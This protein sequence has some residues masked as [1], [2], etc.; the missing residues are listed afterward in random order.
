M[1]L[2]QTLEELRGY[3]KLERVL[4]LFCVA[5]PLLM[6]WVDDGP[7]RDS[8]SAYY[9]MTQNQWFYFPLTAAAMLFLVNG[10]VKG[11]AWYNAWLGVFLTGVVLLNHQDFKLPHGAFAIAFFVGN[12]VVMLFYSRKV[13]VRFRVLVLVGVV[14][15]FLA[16]KP[17]NW[18]SLFVAEWISLGL[19]A[20]HFLLDASK[21][22]DYRAAGRGEGPALRW[23]TLDKRMT[24]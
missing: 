6:I 1:D 19:I 3:A 17:L 13:T 9:N 12:A 5:S 8:I 21:T 14:C 7:V 4:A 10:F 16:W 22:A 20:A 15:A 23:Q 11:Q 24:S 18:Y 2:D